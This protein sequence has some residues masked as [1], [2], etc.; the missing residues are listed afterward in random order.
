MSGSIY[1]LAKKGPLLT[2]TTSEELKRAPT[3]ANRIFERSAGGG[4]MGNLEVTDINMTNSRDLVIT[5]SI[6]ASLSN[7][8]SLSLDRR[9]WRA[10]IA[11]SSH[12][13]AVSI[14]NSGAKVS[15]PWKFGDFSDTDSM[16]VET[17]KFLGGIRVPANDDHGA[18][19]FNS[20]QQHTE[21]LNICK[22][23]GGPNP[24]QIN[25]T[26]IWDQVWWAM[27]ILRVGQSTN[28][29]VWRWR[30]RPAHPASVATQIG[31]LN[32][33]RD[34]CAKINNGKCVNIEMDEA[35]EDVYGMIVYLLGVRQ[36]TFTMHYGRIGGNDR[37]PHILRVD[38]ETI[39][40]H[41]YFRDIL[42][43]SPIVDEEDP[44]LPGLPEGADANGEAVGEF[45]ER[46][47]ARAL[48]IIAECAPIPDDC[49]SAW[50]SNLLLMFGENFHGVHANH[51]IGR[52]NQHQGWDA[53]LREGTLQNPGGNHACNL[54]TQMTNHSVQT[55]NTKELVTRLTDLSIDIGRCRTM[56]EILIVPFQLA[57]RQTG[58]VV[59]TF[60]PR[61]NPAHF[62]RNANY[63]AEARR[64]N[65]KAHASLN[66][67]SDSYPPLLMSMVEA[68]AFKL[69]G[70]RLP[71]TLMYY[72][73][74][75][76]T[77]EAHE[78]PFDQAA[79]L[80]ACVGQCYT[81]VHMA[82]LP[83]NILEDAAVGLAGVPA[84][85]GSLAGEIKFRGT[86]SNNIMVP[87][88]ETN[89]R[90]D[91]ATE[92]E[93]GINMLGHSI[94]LRRDS[95]VAG[96]GHYRV[97]I[98]NV[99][100]TD[101]GYIT[102]EFQNF[103]RVIRRA[104]MPATDA[105]WNTGTDH[106]DDHM[107]L[108]ADFDLL[109]ARELRLGLNT[110]DGAFDIVNG[111]ARRQMLP[112]YTQASIGSYISTGVVGIESNIRFPKRQKRTPTEYANAS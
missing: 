88:G 45:D 80:G 4:M 57:C 49:E 32:H 2:D 41:V 13:V 78:G 20:G 72:R 47:L 18:E 108:Y 5:K 109:N 11:S 84:D 70:A 3:L 28:T 17:K 110:Q 50:W 83:S 8:D 82:Q 34:I 102:F 63:D 74:G 7:S 106:V 12:Q 93:P 69:Y 43:P 104:F 79:G 27:C 22:Q 61:L 62:Y 30:N 36:D 99:P 39:E 64:M 55:G 26:R 52:S 91:G 60:F 86:G 77:A 31:G 65:G 111:Q 68:M 14:R 94:T 112:G 33:Y 48:E 35:D 90:I 58:A 98:G 56:A 97:V 15:H 59:S 6:T 40:Y 89:A 25:T 66:I 23:L 24:K 1:K 29:T 96:D 67:A 37:E 75:S 16:A 19:Y 54:F 71:F 76:E 107:E 9:K 95:N 42:G 51:Y 10:S 92:L 53:F 46:L 101:D 87:I 38:Y 85:L 103:P 21:N 100:N 73:L 44:G 81:S 105:N